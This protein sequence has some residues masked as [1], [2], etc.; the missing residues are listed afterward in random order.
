[1]DAA[2]FNA[3]K[4]KIAKVLKDHAG[5]APAVT[6]GLLPLKELQGKLYEAFVLAEIC[7]QL[8]LT[9]KLSLILKVGKKLILKQKGGAIDKSYPY[10]ELRKGL[11]VFGLMF[12]DIEFLSMSYFSKTGAPFPRYG[13]Y[14]ELDIAIV[15]PFAKNRPSFE[16]IILAV[17]CKFK[18]I[19]KNTIREILGYRREL[20]LL[21]AL[22]LPTKFDYWPVKKVMA[23]P[24]SAQLFYC[25]DP[26]ILRYEEN[27]RFYGIEL[28]HYEM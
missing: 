12:T 3:I 2:E 1:M 26:A 11:N 23:N 13:D 16:H 24:P 19:E 6:Y 14:H 7:K 25:K 17:E 15:V 9:E 4:N 22:P 28:L 20:S 21:T 10:F 5:V 8:V 27:C 18:L